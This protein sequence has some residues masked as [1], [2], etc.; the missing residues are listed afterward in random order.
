MISMELGTGSLFDLPATARVEAD[1]PVPAPVAPSASEVLLTGIRDAQSVI[2]DQ[3]I[4][5]IQQIVAWAALHTVT[6]ASG[7]ASTLTERGLDTEIPVAGPGAPLL[8]DFAV[9]DLAVVLG[10]SKDSGRAYIGQVVELAYRLP[11]TYA[12][13]IAGQVPVW[14]ALRI[15]DTTR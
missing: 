12:R 8:S 10:R 2:A 7:E 3:E 1:Q 4:V 15:A 5:K 14:K 11:A 6:D 13:V 9:M